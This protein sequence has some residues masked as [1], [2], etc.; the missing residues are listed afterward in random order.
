M[1]DP[2]EPMSLFEM[3]RLGGSAVAKVDRMGRRGVTLVTEP[4]IEAMAA[5]IIA[6]DALPG[7]PDSPIRQPI[8]PQIEKDKT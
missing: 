5:L 2:V 7:T 4:E 8:F 6:A 3:N 1:P